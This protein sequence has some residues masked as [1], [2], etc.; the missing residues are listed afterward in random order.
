[1][2]KKHVCCKIIYYSSDDHNQWSHTQNAGTTIH[3]NWLILLYRTSDWPICEWISSV[4][5]NQIF[6][7]RPKVGFVA[8]SRIPDMTYYPR[9]SH[10]PD[11]SPISWIFS[12]LGYFVA[13]SSQ[14]SWVW[15]VV[16]SIFSDNHR[17]I[18]PQWWNWLGAGYVAI[19]DCD[20]PF[21]QT[22]S[23]SIFPSSCYH[24]LICPHQLK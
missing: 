4:V 6:L 2:K 20:I 10:L 16:P 7:L 21:I 8:Q 1:M 12:Y 9:Y 22:S 5:F 13:S 18:G 23:N 14:Y 24:R 17:Q 19:E 3:N 11:I 15:N